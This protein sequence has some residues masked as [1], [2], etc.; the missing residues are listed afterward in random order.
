MQAFASKHT[1]TW[2]HPSANSYNTNNLCGLAILPARIMKKENSLIEKHK[3]KAK[4]AFE[5]YIDK[6]IERVKDKVLV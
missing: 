1:G 3:S 5:S 4:G 2:L 6:D